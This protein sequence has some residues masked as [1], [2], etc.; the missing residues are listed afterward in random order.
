LEAFEKGELEKAASAF[1]AGLKEFPQH[2][3]S[4]YYLANVAYIGKDFP[5][6]LKHMDLAL[7]NFETLRSLSTL[8]DEQKLKQMDSIRATMEQMWDSTTS[9]RDSRALEFGEDELEVQEFSL[10]RAARKREEMYQRMK[11]HYLYFQGNVFFQLNR[12]PEA[13]RAYEEAVRLNPLHADAHN[14]LVA[15]A[16]LARQYPTALALLEKA[17]AQGLEESLNLE[18]KERLFQA[19]GRPTAGILQEDLSVGGAERLEIRRFSLAFRPDRPLAPRLYVNSYI[20]SNP[21]TKAAVLVDPGVADQRLEA[22]VR[23]RGLSIKAVLNTHDHPDHSG[24]NATYAQLFGA[25][26]CAPRDDARFYDSPPDRLLKDGDVLTFDGLTIRVLQTPGHTD[27][28][29]CY[30]VEG[31]LFSGDT[32]LKGDIGVV[33]TDRPEKRAEARRKLVRSIREKILT[34][35]E[36]TLVCP[37]HGRTTSVGA[38]KASNAALAK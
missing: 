31:A 6:A 16:Y 28:S 14:N 25:P 23:E 7:A 21:R 27:G 17:E 29:L 35:P 15:I 3:L 33:S 20:V 30:L 4:S 10:E 12:V 13:F 26:V 34:L 22:F 24:A 11:A 36:G 38:E 18:L 9:C 2:A 8:A 1:Q 5:A 37:G 19:T 32:L